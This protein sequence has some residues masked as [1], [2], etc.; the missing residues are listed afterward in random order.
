[1]LIAA[2]NGGPVELQDIRVHEE[3]YPA[4]QLGEFQSSNLLLDRIWQ[5]GVDTLYPNMTD[6]Y[7]DTPWRERGQW[8]G[9]AYVGERI[10]QVAFGD[11]TLLRRGLSLMA[12]GFEQG[13]PPAR[14]PHGGGELM[15]DYGMLWVQSLHDYWHM[16]EDEG[17]MAQLYPVL[18]AF[19]S[20][21]EGYE[22]A[23]TGLLDVPLGNWWETA[24]IDW[25]GYHSRY[26]QSTAINALYY[27]T[28]LDAARIAE[29]VGKADDAGAWRQKARWIKDQVNAHLYIPSQQQYATTVY[30]GES[31][32]ASVHAQAWPLA[33]GVVPEENETDVASALLDML[34]SATDSVFSPSISIYGM[35]WVLEALGRADRISEA[36]DLIQGYYGRLLDLGAT[37]WWEDFDS[38]MRYNSSLSHCWGGAPTW[39]L[40]SYVLGARRAGRDSWEVR[41]AFSGVEHATGTLPLREGFLNVRWERR[42]RTEGYLKVAAPDNT[43]GEIVVPDVDDTMVLM[44]DDR[45]IWRK[46]TVLM[47]GI[48]IRDGDIR[49]PV[50]GGLHILRAHLGYQ[51]W[52]S[53][54][55][56]P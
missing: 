24:L 45:V 3:R 42:S 55:L 30:G 11:T 26:G 49:I 32:T 31:I 39:F 48:A 14:A 23:S 50:S 54:P 53:R 18:S 40:T 2:W 16:T 37:T 19:M 36:V 8:W 28:L 52:S 7:T 35:F 6:A 34:P 21:L 41:P 38:H 25:R 20:Y 15:L 12:E 56:L 9:D 10:N 4:I 47:N 1:M 44:L 51:G 22:N 17:F 46:G 29:A 27:G 13:R 33:Y 5:V 43:R